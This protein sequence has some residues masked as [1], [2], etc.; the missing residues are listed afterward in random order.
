MEDP[1]EMDENDKMMHDMIQEAEV[2]DEGQRETLKSVIKKHKKM[3]MRKGEPITP[4]L[5]T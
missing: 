1:L 5:R 4:L 3:F 2:E